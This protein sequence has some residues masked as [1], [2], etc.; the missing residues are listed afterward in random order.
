MRAAP[1]GVPLRHNNV[2]DLAGVRPR[3]HTVGT[4]GEIRRAHPSKVGVDLVH[5]GICKIVVGAVDGAK[6]ERHVYSPLQGGNCPGSR[7]IGSVSDGA[8]MI[9]Y[10]RRVIVERRHASF[11]EACSTRMQPALCA[12][13]NIMSARGSEMY[14]RRRGFVLAS[15]LARNRRVTSSHGLEL[16]RYAR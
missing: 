4:V 14:K 7:S 12:L 16:R 5:S 10:D 3:C 2:A 11:S 9:L 8:L 1:S 6:L 15:P 13:R